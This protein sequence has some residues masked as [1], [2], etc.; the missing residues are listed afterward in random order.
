MTHACMVSSPEILRRLQTMVNVV[1]FSPDSR[2]LVSGDASGAIKWVM[3]VLVVASAAP[4][5]A[6]LSHE[7]SLWPCQPWACGPV[8]PISCSCP[9]LSF[10]FPNSIPHLLS[11]MP[12]PVHL[13]GLLPLSLG[14]SFVRL[15]SSPIITLCSMHLHPEHVISTCLPMHQ[16]GVGPADRR[17]PTHAEDTLSRDDQCGPKS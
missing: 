10:N 14:M 17:M 3:R 16:Q 5:P 8:S 15:C 12:S 11:K 13:A 4:A 6:H 9:H 2:A 1:A 7:K